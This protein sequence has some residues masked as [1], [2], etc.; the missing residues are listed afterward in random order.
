LPCFLSQ[1]NPVHTLSPYFFKSHFNIIL[2]YT[3]M[4]SEWSLLFRLSN[5]NVA[6]IFHLPMCAIHPAH[7]MILIICG[8]EYKLW[9]TSLCS[10][11]HLPVTSSLL[12]PNILLSTL[13]SNTLNLCSSLRDQVLHP[14]KTTVN[15]HGLAL[16]YPITFRV[17][18]QFQI[19]FKSIEW[20]RIWNK[21][22]LRVIR[23]FDVLCAKKA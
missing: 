14:Y 22:C 16:K 19:S 3:P 21:H 23:P 13:F 12:G 1:M 2:R 6:R 5:Q 15:L 9:S 20:F 17:G 8:E 18:R 4:S 11:L 10:F 7:V